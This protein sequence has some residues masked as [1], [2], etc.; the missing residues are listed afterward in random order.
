MLE[1]RQDSDFS[2]GRRNAM[3]RMAK[4]SCA[5]GTA[6]VTMCARASTGPTSTGYAVVYL[7]CATYGN[8][9]YSEHG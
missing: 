5:A 1:N 7:D 6:I 3:K 9:G 4:I 8:S 2:H